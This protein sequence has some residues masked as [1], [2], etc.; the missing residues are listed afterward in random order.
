MF[1]V[2]VSSDTYGQHRCIA[3]N[4]SSGGMFLET[5]DPLPLGSLIRVHFVMEGGQGEITVQAQVKNHYFLN[6]QDNDRLKTTVGMGVKFLSFE[7][8]GHQELNDCFT[9]YKTLH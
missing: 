5:G 9:R 6:Y 4:I 3:R 8:N 2:L 7:E 1:S